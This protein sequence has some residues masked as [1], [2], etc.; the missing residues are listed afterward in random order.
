MEVVFSDWEATNVGPALWDIAYMSTLSQEAEERRA[1]KPRMLELY[2]EALGKGGVVV[3]ME[4]AVEQLG[5][6][7]LVLYFISASVAKNALWSGHGNTTKDG[8][9]W[10][11]RV[12]QAV[13][14]LTAT[15]AARSALGKALDLPASQMEGLCVLCREGL[16]EA[17]LVEQELA[18][19]QEQ[20]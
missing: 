14:D 13:I 15:E 8:R 19:A 17:L 9:V 7:Q 11:L 10:G 20:P 18:A 4:A 3:E 5:L 16:A 2:L 12:A 6:L 1:R